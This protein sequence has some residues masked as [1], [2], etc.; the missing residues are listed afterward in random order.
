MIA[1]NLS[2]KGYFG[3]DPE[4]ILKAPVDLVIGALKFEDTVSDY[5]NTYMELNKDG[6]S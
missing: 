5:E 4:R 2:K 6:R 1:F 3:G